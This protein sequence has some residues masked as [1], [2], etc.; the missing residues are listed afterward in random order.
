MDDRD[1]ELKPFLEATVAANRKIVE[2]GGQ[3]D[4]DL[5]GRVFNPATTCGSPTTT[6]GR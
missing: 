4:P 2:T 3:Y 1:A 5:S 6:S